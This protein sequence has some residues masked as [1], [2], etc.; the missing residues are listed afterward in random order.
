RTGC[1]VLWAFPRLPT[2]AVEV[3]VCVLEAV[4]CVVSWPVSGGPRVV[5]LQIP[6][7]SQQQWQPRALTD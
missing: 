7:S 6:R 3:K 5:W 4:E 2:V 1:D